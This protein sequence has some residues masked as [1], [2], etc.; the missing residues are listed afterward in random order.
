VTEDPRIALVKQGFDAWEA[1]DVEATISL[2]DP[3]I[4]VY[5][6][7]EIGN[8][9]TYHGIAGF[10]SWVQAWL[11]AWDTFEQDL[12]A[13]ESVGER[14]VVSRVMQ[15]GV[16]KGSGIRV[17]R[18]ATYVYEIEDERLTFM[19]LFFDHDAALALALEREAAG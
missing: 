11:E 18:E 8:S 1:G 3:D 17:D 13:I 12:L 9:G 6:P 15:H 4:E 7:P 2:Y 5:A 10:H 14:H 19:A 16:G